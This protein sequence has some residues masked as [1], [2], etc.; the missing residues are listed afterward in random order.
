MIK[1]QVIRGVYK[2]ENETVAGLLLG[3]KE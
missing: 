2:F 3:V 1:Q